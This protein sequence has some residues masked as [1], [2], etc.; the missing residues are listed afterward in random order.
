MYTEPKNAPCFY[1]SFYPGISQISSAAPEQS[2]PKEVPILDKL[3]DH[4]Y[5]ES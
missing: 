3:S 4:Y 1:R 5:L 2:N